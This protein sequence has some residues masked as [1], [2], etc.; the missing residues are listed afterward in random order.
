MLDVGLV[1]ETMVTRERPPA[2][3]CF[4]LQEPGRSRTSTLSPCRAVELVEVHPIT[5]YIPV[6]LHPRQTDDGCPKAESTWRQLQVLGI[7]VNL[8]RK[9]LFDGVPLKP[10]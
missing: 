4:P 1:D 2:V 9:E 7:P 6:E 8:G 5:V 3:L 10:P